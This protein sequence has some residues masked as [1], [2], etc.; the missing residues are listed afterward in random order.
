MMVRQNVAGFRRALFPAM[1]IVFL[2][3]LALSV[4]EAIYQTPQGTPWFYIA[5]GIGFTA[6]SATILF[7]TLC[8]CEYYMM[9]DVLVVRLFLC[10]REWQRH[11]VRLHTGSAVFYKGYRRMFGLRL[12]HRT[13]F[14]YI[15]FFG[16]FHK[17]SI[18]FTDSNGKR[19]KIVLK[20]SA[21][22]A[23]AIENALALYAIKPSS[24]K[25]KHRP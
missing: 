23:E 5:L 16:G 20:P 9:Q 1:A 15:P 12:G 2:F 6:V 7:C 13:R 11:V 24:K 17:A 18:L 14:C 8:S 25:Q 3:L 10:G 21:E 19:C 22:L 4:G